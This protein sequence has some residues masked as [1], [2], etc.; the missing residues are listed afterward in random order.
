MTTSPENIMLLLHEQAH[1]ELFDQTSEETFSTLSDTLAYLEDKV[2]QGDFEVLMNAAALLLREEE[3]KMYPAPL[4]AF[5]FEVRNGLR[6][7]EGGRQA[8]TG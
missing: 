8:L 1:D 6:V 3:R 4:R 2:D 5:Q 7:I